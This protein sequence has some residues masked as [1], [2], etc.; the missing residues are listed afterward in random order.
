MAEIVIEITGKEPAPDPNLPSHLFPGCG[1]DHGTFRVLGDAPGYRCIIADAIESVTVDP[2]QVN[3]Y[4]PDGTGSF[5]V[6][7]GDAPEPGTVIRWQVP[8]D[9][10]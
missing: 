1:S 10:C 7:D 4:G 8:D 2:V 5:V 9:E 6:V 3:R